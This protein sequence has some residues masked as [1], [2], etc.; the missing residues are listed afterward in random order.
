MDWHDANNWSTTSGGA[1]GAGVPTSADDVY[2]DGNGYVLCWAMS[3]IACL[4]LN[5]TSTMTE[6][7]LIDQG[8]I[9]NGDY[10]QD[11]GYIGPTG[12]GGYILEFKGN[13]LFT[14]GTFAV[15]TGTGRDPEC[16]FSGTS[17]T[18]VNDSP[19]A[20]TYQHLTFSGSYTLSGTRLSVAYVNQEFSVTGT[21]AIVSGNRIDLD[22]TWPTLTGSI[23]G[24]GQIFWHYVGG[25]SIPTTGTINCQFL[26]FYIEDTLVTLNARTYGGH[27]DVEIEYTATGQTFQF[28]ADGRHQFDH[29]LT[30]YC[31]VAGV[32]ATFDL[33]TNDAEIYVDDEFDVDNNA[34]PNGGTFHVKW[35]NGIQV[36]RHRVDFYFAYSYANTHLDVTQGPEGV[37][38]L[39][40]KGRVLISP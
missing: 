12:G 13:Y 39:W 40:P 21:M 28:L 31:N 32:D 22:G 17:K 15:G 11:G 25:L 20:A 26:T 19:S 9:I 29:N 37:I 4:D 24:D 8:G 36:F 33:E 5:L 16:V 34:F 10:T 6:S 27:C 30:I 1:G 18:Y 14:G 3:P 38:F 23:T 35:G 2:L 7:L